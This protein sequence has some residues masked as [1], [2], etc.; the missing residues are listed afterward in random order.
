MVC[1]TFFYKYIYTHAYKL[2]YTETKCVSY[3]NRIYFVVHHKNTVSRSLGSTD[4]SLYV[5][6]VIG[7]TV[8]TVPSE[9]AT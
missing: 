6:S 5:V 4:Y 1:N 7:I 8:Q 2:R 9:T 3:I